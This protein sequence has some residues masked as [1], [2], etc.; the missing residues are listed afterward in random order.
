MTVRG[1]NIGLTTTDWA[2]FELKLFEH[3]HEH[4]LNSY[5]S[6][7]FQQL[8]GSD[9]V[10]WL[11]LALIWSDTDI[12]PSRRT[13]EGFSVIQGWD[14]GWPCCYHHTQAMRMPIDQSWQRGIFLQERT[15]IHQHIT[16]LVRELVLLF[17][18]DQL[19]SQRQS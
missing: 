9:P 11:V 1:H 14:P 12:L 17:C 15:T 7:L 18:S 10:L 8:A 5:Q 19:S 2:A 4:Q 3:Y 6:S 13:K 16:C